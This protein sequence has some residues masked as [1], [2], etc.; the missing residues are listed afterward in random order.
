M[1]TRPWNTALAMD[2]DDVGRALMTDRLLAD[3]ANT[4]LKDGEQPLLVLLT[5]AIVARLLVL[6]ALLVKDRRRRK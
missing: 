2:L 3:V 6:V 5:I 4:N 1:Y